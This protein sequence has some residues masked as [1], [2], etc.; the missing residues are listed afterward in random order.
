MDKKYLISIEILHLVAGFSL[1][2]SG[3]LV[4]FIDGFEMALSWTIFGAMYVS[5]SD[6]GEED[7]NEEKRKNTKHLNR[8]LFGYVGASLSILLFIYYATKL[9]L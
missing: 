1:V 6:V 4:Y 7:M 8:R 2:A 3:I 9:C 5:M